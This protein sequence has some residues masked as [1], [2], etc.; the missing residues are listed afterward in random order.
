MYTHTLYISS[1]MLNKLKGSR[2]HPIP[3]GGTMST[4]SKGKS[5]FQKFYTQPRCH[6]YIKAETF[7]NHQIRHCSLRVT[8]KSSLQGNESKISDMERP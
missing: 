1:S 5:T 3:D 4:R 7:L 6:S 8:I 2:K